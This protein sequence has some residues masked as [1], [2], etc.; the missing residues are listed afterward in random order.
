MNICT[1]AGTRPELIKLAAT[2]PVLDQRFEQTFI[3]T[4]QNFRP[5]L[6]TNII[7]D[8]ELRQPDYFLDLNGEIGIP[9][10]SQM[11]SAVDEILN[12]KNFD[13]FIVLGDTYSGLTAYTAK[14]RKIP[15]F[16]WKLGIVKIKIFQ[17][18]NRKIIDHL[19]DVNLVYSEHARQNLINEGI[20]SELILKRKPDA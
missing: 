12:S 5:S 3:Y 4:G 19:S 11:M 20:K 18:V 9:A 17:R 13:A 1:V 8:L 7:E 6:A 2:L 16:T 14:R 15:L 10:L